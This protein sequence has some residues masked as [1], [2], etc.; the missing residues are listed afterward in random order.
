[1]NAKVLI[2]CPNISEK[3]GVA[4]YYKLIQKHFASEIVSLDF[5]YTG[6]ELNKNGLFARIAKSLF[7]LISLVNIIPRYDLIVLNPSLDIKAVIRD[8][9]FHF[10]AKKLFRCKTIVFFHGWDIHFEGVIDRYGKVL[11][12]FLFA[13]NRLLVLSKAFARTLVL[14]GFHPKVIGLETTVYEY[15]EHN[16]EKDPRNII[17]LGS[18][19][20]E[21]GCFEAIQT[22]EILAK[23]FPDVNLYMAGDG[24]LSSELKEYAAKHN[25]RNVIFT[26]WLEA[27][28]RDQLLS[29]CGIML[30]PTY[31]EG[32][33]LSL[34][35]GMGAGLAVVTRPVGGIPDI[36][37]ENENGYLVESLDPCDFAEKIKRFL[38]DRRLWEAVSERNRKKAKES[39]EVKHVVK[40]LEKLYL[41]TI[42]DIG[43][44]EIISYA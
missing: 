39:F 6:K 15:Q 20:K 7:D 36:F 43:E 10:F 37:I 25:L 4:Y 12:R 42:Y 11:F 8:G 3:G 40:R 5:Y 30:F 17:F 13:S 16:G 18:L 34:L 14:W 1:M 44:T 2:L 23:N 9:I 29:Q 35:E 24:N 32:M 38:I 33:P 28:E 26:G 22:I 19:K 31:S 41:S 21:K 27:K